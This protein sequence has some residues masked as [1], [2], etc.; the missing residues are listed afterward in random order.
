MPP[1]PSTSPT[2]LHQHK[3]ADLPLVENRATPET[4]RHNP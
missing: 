1:E 3:I 4:E 2:I